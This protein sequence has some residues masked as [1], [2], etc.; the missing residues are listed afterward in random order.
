MLVPQQAGLRMQ[1]LE[2]SAIGLRAARHRLASPDHPAEVTLFPMVHVGE[3][4]FYDRVT[5]EALGHDVVL[6]EGVHARSA[7]I[8]TRA[9]RW[10]PLRRLGL[11]LQGRIEPGASEAEVILADMSGPEFEARWRAMPAWLRAAV[12]VAAQ[13]YGLWLRLTATRAGLVRRQSQDDLAARDLTLMHGTLAEGPLALLLE[14]RD[15]HLRKALAHQL[16]RAGGGG[17]PRRIAVVF[18][19]AHMPAVLAELRTRGDFRPAESS[20]L[21]VIR[22]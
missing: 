11:V 10:L 7:R 19:A 17:R 18:G 20:W 1:F 5:Q 13:G 22:L 15:A 21:D 9:Y 16:D 14:A 3:P 4:G 12:L 6:V 2:S 8:I